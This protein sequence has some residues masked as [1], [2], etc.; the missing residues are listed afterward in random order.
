MKKLVLIMV[1]V[2]SI[3]ATGCNLGKSSSDITDL[4]EYTIDNG[5]HTVVGVGKW[6]KSKTLFV[7]NS[8][9]GNEWEV[10]ATVSII[11]GPVTLESFKRTTK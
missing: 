3:F 4:R 2:L 8:Y 1:L 9:D 11:E 6:N 10:S 7:I 5:L